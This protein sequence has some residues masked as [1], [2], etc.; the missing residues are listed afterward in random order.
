MYRVA[1]DA[2]NL[3]RR[4]RGAPDSH[5]TQVVSVASETAVQDGAGD[6][7]V[8]PNNLGDIS[9][10]GD[11]RSSRPV[12]A[13]AARLRWRKVARGHRFKVGIAIEAL[14][15][16]GVAVQA[17][18]AADEFRGLRKASRPKRASQQKT[19]NG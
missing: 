11:M 17:H 4:V 10:A 7:P 8:E 6:Q 3:A 19:D 13:L 18:P 9:A 14:S 12:A 1:G 15:D 5:L 2:A 16:F